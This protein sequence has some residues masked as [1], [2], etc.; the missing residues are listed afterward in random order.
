MAWSAPNPV[1]ASWGVG[2]F[3]VVALGEEYPALPLVVEPGPDDPAGASEQQCYGA[4]A[5]SAGGAGRQSA[6]PIL[7]GLG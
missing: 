7:P 6:R 3:D 5:A 2:R 1:A 4:R